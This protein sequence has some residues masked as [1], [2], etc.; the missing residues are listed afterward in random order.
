MRTNLIERETYEWG[1]GAA[2]VRE[3]LG[4]LLQ[5][6]NRDAVLL[7]GRFERNQTQAGAPGRGQ[8][9]VTAGARTG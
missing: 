6:R 5:R 8:T 7:E 4:S 2:V 9:G 1:D 3:V